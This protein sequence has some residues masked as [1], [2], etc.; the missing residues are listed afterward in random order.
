MFDCIV[1][2]KGLLGA[3]ATRYLSQHLPNV[4]VIGPDEPRDPTHHTGIYGAHYDETRLLH[5]LNA[6]LVWVELTLRSLAAFVEIERESGLHFYQPSNSLYVANPTLGAPVFDVVEAIAA[7]FDL[8][9][10]WLDR[11]GQQALWPYLHFPAECR[12]LHERPP[13]GILNPR[14]LIQAQLHLAELHNA[15]IIPDI[16]TAVE[17]KPDHMVVTTQNGTQYQA[18]KVVLA[19]GAFSNS[20][21]LTPQKMTLRLKTEFILMA[22]V[23]PGETH[24]LGSMPTIIYDIDSPTINDI[25]L[26]PPVR[27]PDGHTYLKLGANTSADRAV[28][29]LEEIC[30]WYRQG[31]S[32]VML[33]ALREALTSILPDVQ[34]EHWRTTRCVI[35]YTP[36]HHPYIDR[37]IP[38]KLYTAIGGN[39]QAAQ[40]SD[41][42]GRL[43]AELTLHDRWSDP[44]AATTFQLC[45]ANIPFS[46]EHN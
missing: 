12:I 26:L 32:E 29:T 35:T 22:Q 24:R 2:G 21:N 34:V 18:R 19:S 23:S 9:V 27:Y 20:F 30:D 4:A 13:S 10:E 33:P 43:A 31:N 8:P 7:R 42:I 3:A 37:L 17:E 5:R 45:P 6:D 39:G 38:G 40:A 11:A 28:E 36:H 15:T 41:A 16:V 14:R 44:L 46:I 1:V 25:Y